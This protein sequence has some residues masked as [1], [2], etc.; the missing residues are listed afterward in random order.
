MVFRHAT[1]I[2]IWVRWCLGNLGVCF[3][4]VQPD[5]PRI[6]TS[7]YTAP[8]QCGGHTC[9]GLCT[10]RSLITPESVAKPSRRGHPELATKTLHTDRPHTAESSAGLVGASSA[11]P[12]AR[13][14]TVAPPADAE[15]AWEAEDVIVR[16]R[17]RRRQCQIYLTET[18]NSVH[19][20]V[21]KN[22]LLFL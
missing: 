9:P 6:H 4:V 11:F 17:T 10:L 2:G 22:N 13:L 12:S 20:G 19:G 18:P 3:W 5:C 21:R 15:S 14:S 1:Q 7:V 16:T 8:V